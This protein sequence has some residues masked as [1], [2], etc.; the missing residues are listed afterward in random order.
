MTTIAE[1]IHRL[2]GAVARRPGF[3]VGTNR[4]RSHLPEGMKCTSEEVDWTIETD[5]VPALGGTGSAPSPGTLLRAALGSCMAMT[6][7]LRA[8]RAGIEVGAITVTVETDSAIEGMLFTDADVPPGFT[9]MRFHVEIDTDADERDIRRA[10]DEGDR[11]SPVLDTLSRS[12]T[13]TRT[14]VIRKRT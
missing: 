10:I 1:S 5:V 4:S 6:Y 9:G 14:T 2:E 8:E 13:I 12:N 7:R 3:G 11:L